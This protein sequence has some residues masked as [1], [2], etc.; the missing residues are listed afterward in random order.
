MPPSTA[1]TGKFT[2]SL[3]T[4]TVEGTYQLV[5]QLMISSIFNSTF[6]LLTNATV[7]PTSYIVNVIT[8]YVIKFKIANTIL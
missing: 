3:Y 1:P 2:F 8:S 6:G 7:T 4:N 5:D